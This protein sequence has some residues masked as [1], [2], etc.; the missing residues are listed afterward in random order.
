M[1]FPYGV[2][3]DPPVKHHGGGCSKYN[4]GERMFTPYRNGFSTSPIAEWAK[5]IM[6][7]ILIY[8]IFIDRQPL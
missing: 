7:I 8:N 2:T 1:V 6:M 3:G 4:V 5:E